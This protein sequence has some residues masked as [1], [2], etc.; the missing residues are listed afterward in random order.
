MSEPLNFEKGKQ[1]RAA[2]KALNDYGWNLDSV[3]GG[4]EISLVVYF[5]D[6]VHTGY[7]Q[8]VTASMEHVARAELDNECV[9][10]LAINEICGAIDELM[11][12]RDEGKGGIDAQ[13][14]LGR[15][16]LAYVVRTETFK[17]VTLAPGQATHF[18]VFNYHDTHKKVGNL[19]PAIVPLKDGYLTPKDLHGVAE[20]IMHMD[21]GN[22]PEWFPRAAVVPIVPKV[23]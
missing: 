3:V 17:A 4:G 2:K 12:L 7:T 10:D 21:L 19:R 15:L 14:M 8:I 18:I 1:K 6:P 13:N 9:A 11:V 16:L 23:E 22:H 5:Y 20:Q